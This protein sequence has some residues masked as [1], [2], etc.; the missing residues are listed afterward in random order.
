MS[1]TPTSHCERIHSHPRGEY[2]SSSVQ[3]ARELRSTPERTCEPP[4]EH[5]TAT[6]YPHDLQSMSRHSHG[7]DTRTISTCFSPQAGPAMRHHRRHTP[8]DRDRMR[9]PPSQLSASGVSC[10]AFPALTD[11]AR[12]AV[13]ADAAAKLLS[14]ARASERT[15]GRARVC[16]KG[17]P[18]D[19]SCAPPSTSRVARLAEAIVVGLDTQPL[20]CLRLHVHTISRRS[21]PVEGR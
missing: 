5:Q 4:A 13:L 6:H 19:A 8:V 3:P 2:R 7:H 21:T 15:A 18:F 20:A 12:P 14:E 16:E 1:V 10:A 17:R 9:A 11:G